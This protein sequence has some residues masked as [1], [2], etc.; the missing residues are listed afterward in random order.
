MAGFASIGVLPPLFSL[1]IFIL[2]HGLLTTL[3][4][5]RLTAEQVSPQ[6]IG[7]IS[8]AYFAGLVMGSFINARLITRVGHIRAYAAYASLLAAIAISYG[9]MVSPGTWVILRLAGGFATGGLFVVIESW[10]L[11]SSTPATRGR[12]MALYMILLYGALACGQLLLKFIDPLVLVPFALAA[13]SASLSVVPLS[14]TRVAMPAQAAP[15]PIGFLTLWR[16]TPAGMWGS[17]VSGL[18][19]GV[20]YGLLPL[21]FTASDYSL[22]QVANM[23]AIVILGGMCLQYPLG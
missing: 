7:L 8:T 11:V 13:M 20:I 14:L 17:I 3:L 15:K 5:L 4:T 23:M 1:V 9:L 16:L 18:V 2:G 10:M 6:W 19:L 12:L 22:D 21:F